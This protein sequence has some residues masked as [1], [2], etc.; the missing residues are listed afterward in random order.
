MG[1]K[2]FE[3]A[4]P[5]DYT[6]AQLKKKICKVSGVKDFSFSILRKSLDARKKNNII[7]RLRIG[8]SAAGLKGAAP[9]T[10]SLEIQYEKRIEKVIVVGSGPAGFFAA[11]VLQKAGF[12]VTI[13]ERGLDVDLRAK[14]ITNFEEGGVFNEK[15]NYAFGEG[16]AGTFSDGKLTSRTKSIKKERSFIFESYIK[17]GAPEEI[18]YLTHPHLGT[19]NLKKI[20]KNLRTDFQSIGG[21]IIFDCQLTNINCVSESVKSVETTH[22]EMNCDYLLIAPGHSSFETYRMLMK[23][24]VVFRNKNFAIGSRVEHPQHIINLAQWG[25]ESLPGVKAAEYRLTSQA[26]ENHPVYTFC[27]CPGGTIVPATAYA[28]SN[29]VNGM[30][31][32]GRAGE[33]ANAACVAGVNIEQLTGRETTAL[34]ALDWLQAL[35][36][37]FYEIS[38]EYKAPA[39]SI[40]DFLNQKISTSIGAGSFP[41]GLCEYPFWKALP[42]SVAQAM[43]SGLQDFSDKIKGWDEG[44]IMGLESKTSAPIQALRNREGLAEGFKNLYIVGEGSGWAGGIISSAADGIRAAM[45]LV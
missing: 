31:L 39:V 16:G 44:L 20:V 33:F 5:T 7:W 27:M 32:Y 40:K 35:E 9:V 43:R 45:T 26:D 17:A 28:G 11:Y 22:G 14:G 25:H 41:I 36:K 34:E 15:A 30:S 18:G 37:S 19:D 24:G 4:L 3:L 29:I 42:A 8:L 6:E 23:Q 1:Y 10:P 13:I 2:E 12:Q 38:P 21:R